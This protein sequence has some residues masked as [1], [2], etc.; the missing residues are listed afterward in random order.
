MT[1]EDLHTSDLA[2]KSVESSDP[3]TQSNGAAASPAPRQMNRVSSMSFPNGCGTPTTVGQRLTAC[4]LKLGLTQEQAVSGVMFRPK[5]G[6]RKDRDC[7]LSRNAYCMYERDLVP[8][9]LKMIEN[10]AEAFDESPSWLAFGIGR[11]KI[12]KAKNSRG[13]AGSIASAV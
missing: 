11:S 4:R 9:S 2:A 1:T 13:N 10:I 7:K 8:I 6:K 12:K 5:S 3:T